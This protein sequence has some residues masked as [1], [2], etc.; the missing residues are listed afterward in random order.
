M[1]SI[2]PRIFK[3]QEVGIPNSNTNKE[4]EQILMSLFQD[5][6]KDILEVCDYAKEFNSLSKGPIK[7][8][9]KYI[10]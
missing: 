3:I 8:F 7:I 10:V 2:R 5:Y 6:Q 1:G 9:V 4:Y